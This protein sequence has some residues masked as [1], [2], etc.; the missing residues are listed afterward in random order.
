[1]FNTEVTKG[2]L[3]LW[4]TDGQEEEG[5]HQKQIGSEKRQETG[6]EVCLA[7]EWKGLEWEK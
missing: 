3:F 2:S 1:M 7:I 4:F 6:Q 5:V